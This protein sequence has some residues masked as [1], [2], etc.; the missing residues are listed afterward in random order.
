MDPDTVNS[1]M[2]EREFKG[3]DNFITRFK[4]VD[5]EQSLA[6]SHFEDVA[7]FSSI[8]KSHT[9]QDYSYDQ[10]IANTCAGPCTQFVYPSGGAAGTISDAKPE[11]NI[12]NIENKTGR[13]SWGRRPPNPGSQRQSRWK[14]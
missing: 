4:P 7:C 2:S 6:N 13:L 12:S 11:L 1:E 14:R 5:A 8:H 9:A 10:V 3:D